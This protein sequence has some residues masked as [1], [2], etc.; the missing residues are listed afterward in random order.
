MRLSATTIF[1]IFNDAPPF[2]VENVCPLTKEDAAG[3]ET[4]E[5][6]SVRTNS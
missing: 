5:D 4:P 3:N 6:V 1:E 2:E